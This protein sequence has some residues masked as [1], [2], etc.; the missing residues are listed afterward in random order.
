MPAKTP[1]LDAAIAR[2]GKIVRAMESMSTA[3]RPADEPPTD[4]AKVLVFLCGDRAIDA[5]RPRDAAWGLGLGWFDQDRRRWYVHG[6][7]EYYVTHWMPLPADPETTK[8]RKRKP[9]AG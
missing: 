1:S 9:H 6:R 5:E 2:L 8:P 7:P 4:E 3:W